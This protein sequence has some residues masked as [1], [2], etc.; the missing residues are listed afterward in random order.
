MRKIQLIVSQ[1]QFTKPSFDEI[2]SKIQQEL[3]DK[4]FEEKIINPTDGIEVNPI[5]TKDTTAQT[6]QVNPYLENRVYWQTVGIN[7]DSKNTNNTLLNALENGASGLILDFENIITIQREVLDILFNQVRFDYIYT[8]FTKANSEVISQI[9]SFLNEQ[10]YEI[11][12][13]QIFFDEQVYSITDEKFFDDCKAIF[14]KIDN[15]T[16]NTTSQIRIE[17]KGDF[18]W[19]L[20]K[21]RAFKIL[22]ESIRQKFDLPTNLILAQSNIGT[23]SSVKENNLLM[24]TTQAISG[25]VAGCDGL[26]LETFN[27][28]DSNFSQ[29]MSRNIFNLLIEESYMDKVDDPAFGSYFIENYTQKIASKIYQSL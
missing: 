24:L 22:F 5:Y 8:H 10:K 11:A 27:G 20:C 21:I 19:D 4:S 1:I 13:N 3:K 15:K 12:P 16:F 2:K 29:R 23:G 26:I 25:I 14:Q 28:E 7:N 9:K 17:L 6:I 18:F